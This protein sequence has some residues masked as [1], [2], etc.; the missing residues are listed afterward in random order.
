MVE[1]SLGGRLRSTRQAHG[2]SQADLAGD[3]FSVSYVSLIESGKREPTPATLHRLAERLG[4]EVDFLQSGVRPHEREHRDLQ[5]RYAQL[6]MA[7]GEAADAVTQLGA[8]RAAITTDGDPDFRWQVE[9]ALAAAYESTGDLGAAVSVLEALREQAHREPSRWPWIEVVISLSRCYREAGDLRRAVDVGEDALELARALTPDR[10]VLLPRLVST[11]AAAYYERGDLTRAQQLLDLALAD[12]ERS[13][14]RA[15]RGSV[16]WNSS[17]VAAERGRHGD[18]LALA[19]RAL[20][21]LVEGDDARAIARLK[22]CRAAITLSSP[23]GDVEYARRLLLSARAT[24]LE[25]GSEVD[26][27]YA[28]T[29]LAGANLALGELAEA[30]G[31]A[32]SSLRRLGGQ[33][34]LETG[35]AHLCLAQCLY[36][37]GDPEA[38]AHVQEAGAVLETLKA[39]RQAAQVWRELAEMQLWRGDVERATDSFRRALDAGG[40]PATLAPAVVVGLAPTTAMSSVPDVPD[41]DLDADNRPTWLAS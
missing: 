21:L 8:L 36:A 1:S 20:A 31:Y 22:G 28:E 35:R 13:G 7:H 14:D 2:M 15:Q 26:V 29:C 23:G 30:V 18:A 32:R 37:Q 9:T 27:A 5:L 41:Q 10:A 24:L 39:D 17:I 38:E 25:T 11:L 19:D 33:P 16:L 3:D 12:A 6:A 4:V 40:V 34:R